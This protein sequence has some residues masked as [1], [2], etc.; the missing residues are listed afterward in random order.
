VKLLNLI[1]E[2][3]NSP[4]KFVR[5][6]GISDGAINL[7]K[8][9]EGFVDKAQ[10]DTDGKMIIGYGT[11]IP[12]SSFLKKTITPAEGHNLLKNHINKNVVPAIKKYVTRALNQNQ[13]DALAS[14]VYNIGENN[15]KRSSLLKSI[16]DGDLQGIKK[17]W[18]EWRL[19]MGKPL[20]GLSVRR[21]KEINHFFL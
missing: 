16:N 6:N 15:F 8:N 21:Q 19:S 9:F 2:L 12:D 7:I 5:A 14:L 17:H 20:K 13:W 4:K 1:N 18:S 3:E 11:R 10:A